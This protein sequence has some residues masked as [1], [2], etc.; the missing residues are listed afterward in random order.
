MQMNEDEATQAP[1]PA[2]DQN[3]KTDV[4]TQAGNIAQNPAQLS[5][6]SAHKPVIRTRNTDVLNA[7]RRARLLKKS[8]K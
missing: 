4:G 7:I 5:T 3:T 6:G 8:G 1:P 2:T